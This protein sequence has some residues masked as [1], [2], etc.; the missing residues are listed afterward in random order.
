M[1]KKDLLEKISLVSYQNINQIVVTLY[2]ED[3][4]IA[5]QQIS[6]RSLCCDKPITVK[7]FDLK[8]V[9]LSDVLQKNKGEDFVYNNN[10]Y[11]F[12]IISKLLYVHDSNTGN[13]F[14]VSDENFNL[15]T[16]VHIIQKYMYDK[17]GIRLL[18]IP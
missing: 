6:N 14:D 1:D 15:S 13:D 7:Y 11:L 5:E 4:L 9:P 12:S 16:P 2:K 3:C 8:A 18:L 17:F 10:C